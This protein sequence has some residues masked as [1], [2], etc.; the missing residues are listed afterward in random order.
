MYIR[1][2]KQN[3]DKK[4]EDLVIETLNWWSKYNASKTIYTEKVRSDMK[5]NQK[6]KRSDSNSNLSQDDNE[7]NKAKKPKS[8]RK[9]DRK[10]QRLKLKCRI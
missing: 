3:K 9:I 1:K 2:K 4:S 6:I 5:A 8:I 10:I 7:S